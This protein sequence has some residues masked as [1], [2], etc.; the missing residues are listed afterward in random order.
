MLEELESTKKVK[1][2]SN[3]YSKQEKNISLKDRKMKIGM[4]DFFK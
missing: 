2:N 4:S 3:N 1:N